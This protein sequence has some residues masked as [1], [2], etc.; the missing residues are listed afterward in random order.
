MASF[1]AELPGMFLH[2]AGGAFGSFGR[3]SHKWRGWR[4]MVIHNLGQIAMHF[5]LLT[6]GGV[7][8]DDNTH[9][10]MAHMDPL[11]Q[12]AVPPSGRGASRYL[13]WGIWII[14]TRTH[15]CWPLSLHGL[16]VLS[17]WSLAAVAIIKD[18]WYIPFHDV[19]LVHLSIAILDK[20][21]VWAYQPGVPLSCFFPY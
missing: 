4:G 11:V 12:S 3:I 8:R 6:D 20:D 14:R 9:L 10:T 5:G 16:S 18:P 17:P 21:V 19:L 13:F 15:L 2:S 1:T 7:T